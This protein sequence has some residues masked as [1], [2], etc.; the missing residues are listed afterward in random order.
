MS[1]VV[2]RFLSDIAHIFCRQFLLDLT[3]SRCE[4][5]YRFGEARLHDVISTDIV[6]YIYMVHSRVE[7]SIHG[8]AARD[9]IPS[10]V[11]Y[12]TP[13]PELFPSYQRHGLPHKV[14]TLA[15]VSVPLVLAGVE[16]LELTQK[17]NTHFWLR[18]A[19]GELYPDCLPSWP[20]PT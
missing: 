4:P 20:A 8:Y 5:K 10:L 7:T 1:L 2:D 9:G 17:T 13:R 16:P 14:V 6:I 18:L 3:L 12:S 11:Q 19:T 15:G